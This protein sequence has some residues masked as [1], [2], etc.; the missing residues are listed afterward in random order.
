MNR[1][2]VVVVG[3]G[4][5]GL[6]AAEMLVRNR[7]SVCLV[8]QHPQ[9]GLGASGDHHEW[10]HFG[11]LYSIFPC[12]RYQQ[13]LLSGVASLIKYYAGFSGMNVRIAPTGRLAVDDR[14]GTWFRQDRIN[15]IVA[16]PNDPGFRRA[17]GM[18]WWSALSR[19]ALGLMWNLQ[20]KQFICRHNRFYAYDWRRARPEREIPTYNLFNYSRRNIEKWRNP[21]IRL[22]S[23]SHFLISGYD[24]PME[25]RSILGDLLCS[26]LA[27]GGVLRLGERFESYQRGAGGL[28]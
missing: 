12:I 21:D 11:S 4:I 17:A 13:A 14:P 10:F 18:P 6:A 2:D 20:I 3:G 23:Q 27:G 15:Y 5:A 25:T 19:P 16:A 26:F 1:F 28:L 8:E 7:R 9:I 22:D 24:R